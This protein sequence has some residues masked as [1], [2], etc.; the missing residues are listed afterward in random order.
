MVVPDW[1]T[2]SKVA[3]VCVA[4]L[5]AI[6]TLVPAAEAVEDTFNSPAVLA[7][8]VKLPL[9]ETFRSEPVVKASAAVE[10]TVTSEPEVI[11]L[12]VWFT[13]KPLPVVRP[14]AV[15]LTALPAVVFALVTLKTLAAPVVDTP[16]MLTTLP[17]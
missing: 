9:E 16:V 17:V 8:L 11:A 1:T 15:T 2:F 6:F 7:V 10:L 4:K 12:V 5:L 3:E 14:L 13:F